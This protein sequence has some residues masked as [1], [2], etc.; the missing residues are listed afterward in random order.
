M[1]ELGVKDVDELTHA[2][3]DYMAGRAW[4]VVPASLRIAQPQ[5]VCEWRVRSGLWRRWSPLSIWS[6]AGEILQARMGRG[7]GLYRIRGK[8]ACQFKENGWVAE[9]ITAQGAITKCIILEK[10]GETVPM[11]WVKE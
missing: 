10:Y 3:L 11:L 4:G 7:D 9:S 2:E 6:H 1:T 5:N 8:W